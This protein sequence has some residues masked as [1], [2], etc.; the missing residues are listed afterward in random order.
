MTKTCAD[1]GEQKKYFSIES[2]IEK[3]SME[4]SK[5]FLKSNE[6]LWNS[7]MFM[8]KASTYLNELKKFQ[9]K[10]VALCQKS[11]V[12]KKS[13]SDFIRISNDDFEQC[14]N[15]SIDYAVMEHTNR[16][17]GVPLKAGWSDLGSWESLMNTKNKDKNGNVLE[18]DITSSNTKNT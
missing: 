5:L 7:G 4:E 11:L 9:P 17:A 13:D 2:F 6:Y 12:S 3:P 10:I 15:V 1:F 14:P 18:G 16:S 8:F